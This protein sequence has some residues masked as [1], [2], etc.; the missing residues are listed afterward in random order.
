VDSFIEVM[1]VTVFDIEK[2]NFD[3]DTDDLKKIA[4]LKNII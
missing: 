4:I 3:L 1:G 2:N